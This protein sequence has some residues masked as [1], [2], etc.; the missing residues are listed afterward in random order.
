MTRTLHILLLL[1]SLP[2]AFACSKN[3]AAEEAREESRAWQFA[4][5]KGAVADQA[6]TFR[7]S[8]L[9]NGTGALR[10]DGSYSGYYTASGWL[11]PC[12]TDNDGNA[13]DT[14][15]S[16][17]AW[18]DPD[19]FTKTDKDS[20]YALRGPSASGYTLV[21]TSPAV[22]MDKFLPTGMPDLPA[23]YKWG[24]P[25]DRRSSTWA[26]SAPMEN[27]TLNA[28]Y[29]DENYIFTIDPTLYEH[30]AKLTVKVACGS[31]AMVDINSVYFQNVM[32][33]AWYMPKTQTYEEWVMDGGTG[34]PLTNYYTD[35]SY[36]SGLETQTGE[37]EKM[38]VP[39]LGDEIHLVKREGQ[40]THF[41]TDGEWAD[42]TDSDEW[43]LGDDT[44]SIVTAIKDFPILPLN[45]ASLDG[46]V[47]R[48]AALMPQ[49]VVLTGPGGNIRST[50]TLAAN[51]EP[52]KA[53]TLYIYVSNVYAQAILTVTDWEEE[54]LSA[55]FGSAQQMDGVLLGITDWNTVN[56]N[57]ND[58]E[59]TNN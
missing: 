30:R 18:D 20:Q 12:R 6:V 41:I 33:T 15:G 42:F 9:H 4:L 22:R 48:F 57:A 29:L 46:D 59:I 51:I 1:L 16:V 27:L 52:M 47:Y 13:L 7:A 37:G 35:N 55:S 25:I 24:F 40:T 34:S 8:L 2:L 21:F 10:S 45:Y 17:I 39:A 54:S 56:T 32:S 19:W 44:K 36:P 53:Y 14:G 43:V 5:T 26:V 28:T 11:Y 31:L 49:I 50:V 58:G 23:N 38:V 3:T